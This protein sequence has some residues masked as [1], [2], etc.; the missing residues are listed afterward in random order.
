MGLTSDWVVWSPA[1]VLGVGILVP[2][3]R[4]SMHPMTGLGRRGGKVLVCLL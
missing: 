1:V 3:L 4:P 2:E